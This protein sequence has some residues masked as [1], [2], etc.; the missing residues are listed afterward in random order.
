MIKRVKFWFGGVWKQKSC[1]IGFQELEE[2]CTESEYIYGS[3]HYLKTSSLHPES[4]NLFK[5]GFKEWLSIF[6]KELK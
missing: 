6:D 2:T 3:I 1:K 5:E 4:G